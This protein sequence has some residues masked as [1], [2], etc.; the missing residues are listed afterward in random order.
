LERWCGICAYDGTA[1][2]GW[3]SQRSGNAVQDF[4][5]KRLGEIFGQPISVVGSGRTDAGVH[6]IG[7]VF[8]FDAPHWCHGEGALLRAIRWRLPRSIMPWKVVA[9]GGEFHARFSATG[10][11]YAY[12]M[13]RGFGDPFSQRYRWS[14][15]AEK[16]HLDSMAAAAEKFIG[17]HDF[18]NFSN[19]S[20]NE[21]TVRTLR[22]SEIVVDGDAIAY[23]TEGDGYLYRMVRRIVGALVAVG[24]AKVPVELLGEL[25]CGPAVAQSRYLQTAPPEGLFLDRVFYGD[26]EPAEH[27]AEAGGDYAVARPWCC[28]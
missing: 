27:F 26:W 21:N 25:L 1:F 20:A 2:D 6:A 3:Q 19:R 14:L 12:A 16:L 13:A 11:R 7:Q 10:K 18:A 5:Q 24:R 4:L 17:T 23:V 8:H 22:R 28:R 9:V 15:G